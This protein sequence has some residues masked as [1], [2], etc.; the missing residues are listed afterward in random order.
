LR[1]AGFVAL[2][3][4]RRGGRDSGRAC[5]IPLP[6]RID[7]SENGGTATILIDMHAFR[8]SRLPDRAEPADET[9]LAAAICLVDDENVERARDRAILELGGLGWERCRFDGV[10]RMREP[11]QLQSMSDAMQTACRR[12]RQLGAAVILYPAPGDAVPG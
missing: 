6:G 7:T 8:V 1:P 9:V 3:Y 2:Q 5:R 10:A 4:G 12:A 11:L